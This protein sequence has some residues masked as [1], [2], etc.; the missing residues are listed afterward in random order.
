MLL[1]LHERSRGLS[2]HALLR[3][4]ATHRGLPLA[5]ALSHLLLLLLALLLQL[6][7]LCLPL[8][9]LLLLRWR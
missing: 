9:L 6:W 3:C 1:L 5:S 4:P 7:Q 8:L 2:N